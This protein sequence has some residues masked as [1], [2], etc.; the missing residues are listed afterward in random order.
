MSDVD[1]GL[2]IET[3]FGKLKASG[4]SGMFMAALIIAFALGIYVLH[5]DHLA[6]IQALQENRKIL[7]ASVDR[8]QDATDFTNYLLTIPQEAR[9]AIPMATPK[10]FRENQD[11]R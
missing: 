8:L 10:R 9:T 3:R 4:A 5:Q 2:E 1:S 11:A 7:D 6:A